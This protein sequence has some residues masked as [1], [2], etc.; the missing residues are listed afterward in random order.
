MGTKKNPSRFT[1]KFNPDYLRHREAIRILS[2]AGRGKAT[3]I[4]DVL[5]MYSR[6]RENLV[7][8][9]SNDA[10]VKPIPI[11]YNQMDPT[12]AH[13]SPEDNHLAED[14]IWQTVEESI[15]SFFG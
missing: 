4:A 6:D 14:D 11:Q 8:G 13:D 2:E 7:V 9:I 3:L 10:I 15:E 12:T 5:Y 1:I